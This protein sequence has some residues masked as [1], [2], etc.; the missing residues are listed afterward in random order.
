MEQVLRALLL[1][2]D[3]LVAYLAVFSVLVACGLGVPLPED[4][5][6]SLGGYLASK[7]AASLPGM[8]AVG[9]CGILLGD[10]LIF[11]AGRRAGNRVDAGKGLFARVVTPEK[12]ARVEVL[13][14][15]YGE[16]IVM[17]AR[18]MPG[19][20]AVTYFLAGSSGMP[21]SHFIFWDGLAALASAPVFVY[22]GFRF[23]GELEYLLQ[24]LKEGQIVVFGTLIVG[25]L[26]YLGYR[27]WKTRRRTA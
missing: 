17:V 16:K 12:K 20:R 27:A 26:G 2:H 21:Y 25:L 22:L 4:I 19:V 23:G 1:G 11:F 10:S 13:F 9:F 18:F 8:I 5:S 14:K 7:G 24:K 3:G 15:R 6:L